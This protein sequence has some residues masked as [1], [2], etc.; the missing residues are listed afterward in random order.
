VLALGR[1]ISFVFR[2]ERDQADSLDAPLT[3]TPTTT[4]SA[5]GGRAFLLPSVARSLL[6][7]LV[8]NG[9]T[10]HDIVRTTVNWPSIAPRD[11]AGARGGSSAG[12][13]ALVSVHSAC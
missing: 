12:G 10:G 11:K 7:G 8:V 2:K 4:I 1:L 13:F 6:P 3:S 9:P 5:T